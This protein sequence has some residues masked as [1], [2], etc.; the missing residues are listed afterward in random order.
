MKWETYDL[1]DL[2]ATRKMQAFS[3]GEVK[4]EVLPGLEF[5]IFFCVSL[6]LKYYKF[7]T[8]IK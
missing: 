8:V 4:G 5:N 7:S 3:P 6:N 1:Y 2:K